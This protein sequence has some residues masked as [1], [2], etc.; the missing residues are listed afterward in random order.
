MRFDY[1]LLDAP[2]SAEG[3]IMFDKTRKNQD[4]LRR[5]SETCSKKK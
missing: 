4:F 2:Y 3:A 1:V 5:F